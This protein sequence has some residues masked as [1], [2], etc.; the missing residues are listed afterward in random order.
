MLKGYGASGL[1]LC[2]GLEQV[3]CGLSAIGFCLVFN[4]KAS[5]SISDCDPIGSVAFMVLEADLD[6]VLTR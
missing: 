4:S 6:L 2:R 5:G 3:W 1:D